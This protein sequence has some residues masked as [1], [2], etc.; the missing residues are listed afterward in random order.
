MISM[1][2]VDELKFEKVIKTIFLYHNIEQS[3]ELNQIWREDLQNFPSK[4]IYDAWNQWRKDPR[5]EGKRPKSWDIVLAIKNLGYSLDNKNTNDEENLKNP[6]AGRSLA[7]DL[8]IQ[9]QKTM[10]DN[11]PDL[12]DQLKKC[13]TLRERVALCLKALNKTF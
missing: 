3:Q 4:I 7:D 9:Q 13:T 10:R 11:V 12:D 5:N 6:V 1:Q 2:Q 8:L